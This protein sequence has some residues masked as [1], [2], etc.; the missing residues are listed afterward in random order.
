MSN[1]PLHC[2]SENCYFNKSG[3]CH[4]C[5]IKIAGNTAT[6]TS[7]TCCESFQNKYEATPSFTN[8]VDQTFTKVGTE[9]IS[10][11][12]QNCRHNKNQ[13]CVAPTVKINPETASCET[14]CK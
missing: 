14:F 10:C 6:T 8:S 12:A 9:A 5:K 2:E 11:H 4:S 1:N 7:D 3:E 13:A